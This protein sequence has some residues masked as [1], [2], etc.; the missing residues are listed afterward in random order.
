MA[1]QSKRDSSRAEAKAAIIEKRRASKADFEARVAA[2]RTGRK[3]V[4]NIVVYLS[5]CLLYTSDAADDM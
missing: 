1:A 4:S 3:A 5:N 2:K